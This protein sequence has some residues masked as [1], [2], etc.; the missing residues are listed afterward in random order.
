MEKNALQLLK[1]LLDQTSEPYRNELISY[2]SQDFQSVLQKELHYS[3]IPIEKD[4]LDIMHYSWFVPFFK[5]L[6]HPENLYFLIALD[7]SIAI[8]LEGVLHLTRSTLG[9]TNIFKKYLKM[10]MR[11]HLLPKELLPFGFIPDSPF[12]PL[13]LASRK[14]LIDLLHCISLY[15]LALEMRQIVDT[16]TLKRMYNCLSEKD[17]AF[18]NQ[19]HFESESIPWPKMGLEKWDGTKEHLHTLLH[20]RGIYR[21]SLGIQD[22]SFPIRW[23][24]S[25]KLDIGR[26]GLLMKIKPMPVSPQI[27]EKVTQQVVQ[28]FNEIQS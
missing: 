7:E 23:Y 4:P 8:P 28:T 15:D 9:I 26:G 18:L 11:K 21:L 12:R 2:L 14:T 13:A 27:K 5:E 19:Q 24:I 20:R 25:H 17:K 3:Q 1:A 10:M 16:K 6:Q 22:A